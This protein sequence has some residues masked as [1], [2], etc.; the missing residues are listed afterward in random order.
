MQVPGR[1]ALMNAA[2]AGHATCV[3]QLLAASADK[4]IRD[5]ES[6]TAA[7]LAVKAEHNHVVVML[8]GFCELL[9]HKP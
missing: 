6:N 9:V 8:V 4:H 7:M 2:I 5:D 1:T 3:Q